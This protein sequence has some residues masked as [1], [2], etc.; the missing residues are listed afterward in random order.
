MS[1]TI[2][3]PP[4]MA[5]EAREYVTVHGTTLERMFL[6]YLA[7]ELRRREVSNGDI[8]SRVRALRGIVNVPQEKDDS[9]LIRDA[10]LDKYEALA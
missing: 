10:I 9:D 2:D 3:L 6:D 8:D 4:A 7:A 1:I 5:Q